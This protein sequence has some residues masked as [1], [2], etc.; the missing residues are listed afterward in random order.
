MPVLRHDI[1][2]RH[3]LH[4][5]NLPARSELKQ[6]SQGEI[7]MEPLLNEQTKEQIK[8]IFTD[9]KEPV[10]ILFFGTKEQCEYCGE[11][12][13]LVE[14]VTGLSEKLHLSVHDIRADAALAQKY[15][16]ERIPSLVLAARDA[17]QVT[18]FGIRFSGIP[19]GHEFSSFINDLV[20]VSKRDS[21]LGQQTRAFL[22][23]LS[24]PVVLQVF[25][26]PT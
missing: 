4:L 9:L 21:G 24:K 7:Y 13:Q 15:S 12:R 8:Q 1:D 26:T 16:V 2:R 23:G 17:Q 3:R 6:K 10:E 22:K 11:T 19:S 18:D 20:L 25:V 5:I 14:E